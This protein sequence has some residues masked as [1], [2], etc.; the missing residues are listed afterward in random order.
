MCLPKRRLIY[1]NYLSCHDRHLLTYMNHDRAL[2]HRTTDTVTEVLYLNG[3]SLGR[4]GRRHSDEERVAVFQC[5]PP[6]E[7]GRRHARLRRS[8]PPPPSCCCCCLS[9]P[10]SP[11]ATSGENA[12]TRVYQECRVVQCFVS[13]FASSASGGRNVVRLSESEN[14]NSQCNCKHD[15]YGQ[16]PRSFSF[17]F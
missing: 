8:F 15:Q 11:L 2:P 17:S 4:A 7:P 12:T 9:S 10:D 13:P 3:A 6:P 14:P 16:R 1:I 5:S